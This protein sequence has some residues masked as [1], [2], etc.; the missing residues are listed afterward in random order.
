MDGDRLPA[1][2]K[3]KAHSASPKDRIPEHSMKVRREIGLGR[4]QSQRMQLLSKK[5]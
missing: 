2:R 4:P 1:D 5:R 3:A